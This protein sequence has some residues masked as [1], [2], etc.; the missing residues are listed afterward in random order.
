M[1]NGRSTTVLVIEQDTRQREKRAQSFREE[2]FDVVPCVD[3]G[4][5]AQYLRRRPADAVC[6]GLR[7]GGSSAEM[8]LI[9]LVRA[10]MPD[11]IILAHSAY[12]Q[13]DGV[14][15]AFKSGVQDFLTRP[16]RLDEFVFKLKR[17]LLHRALTREDRE[18]TSPTPR[19]EIET[20]GQHPGDA[21]GDGS[22]VGQETET[23]LRAATRSFEREHVQRVLAHCRFDKHVAAEALGIGLSSLYRKLDELSIPLRTIHDGHGVAPHAA[24]NQAVC[25]SG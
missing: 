25:G 20:T 5:A 19:R 7:A 23:N 21:P 11:T 1:N 6:V 14:I 16:D 2:G 12:P 24:A 9:R 8:E 18:L 13:V 3:P 15:E 10:S 4:E 22:M 17:L